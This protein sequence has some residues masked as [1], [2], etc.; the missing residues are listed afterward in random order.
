VF[1]NIRFGL[2]K[3]EVIEQCKI[4]HNGEQPKGIEIRTVMSVKIYVFWDVMTCR[5]GLLCT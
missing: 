5:V 2:K 1:E 4:V 3:D